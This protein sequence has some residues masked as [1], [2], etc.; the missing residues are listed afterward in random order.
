MIFYSLAMPDLIR[1]VH[2]NPHPKAKLIREFS[3]YW[4]LKSAGTLP[5]EEKRPAQSV[6][7]TCSVVASLKDSSMES[8][9]PQSASPID[10]PLKL[11]TPGTIASGI[12]STRHTP[13]GG[14]RV[15]IAN[16]QL[17]MRIASMAVYESRV[18]PAPGA[19]AAAT[20][21]TGSGAVGTVVRR[22]WFVRDEVLAQYAKQLD[23]FGP[24]LPNTWLYVSSITDR[25]ITTAKPAAPFVGNEIH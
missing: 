3:I 12:S 5:F 11:P 20:G 24:L 6:T 16:R 18:V 14:A 19:S 1:L 7:S 21:G 2:G 10:S 23:D 8:A 25:V 17:E 15:V 13:S 4:E 22:C 9:T